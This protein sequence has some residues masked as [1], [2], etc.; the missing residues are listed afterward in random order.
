GRVAMA[1]AADISDVVVQGGEN[2][3]APIARRDRPIEAAAAQNVLDAQSNQRRVL[4]I[5]I[6]RIAAGD[7]LDDEPGGFVQTGANVR[8][9]VAID[10]AVGLGQIPTQCISKKARRVQHHRLLNRPT[11]STQYDTFS[12]IARVLLAKSKAASPNSAAR[13]RAA[14][15][16]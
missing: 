3:M 16:R 6:E 9:L 7:A 14:G 10:P 2:G 11:G 4:A 13:A 15:R 8:L 1:D 12:E 5:V